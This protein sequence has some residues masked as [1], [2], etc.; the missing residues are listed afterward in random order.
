[1][2]VSQA[3]VGIWLLSFLSLSSSGTSIS[4]FNQRYSRV[5]IL[6]TWLQLCFLKQSERTSDGP[7]GVWV[8]GRQAPNRLQCRRQGFEK[9]M[10]RSEDFELA[11]PQSGCSFSKVVG[12][13]KWGSQP[14]RCAYTSFIWSL[15]NFFLK[16][17][18]EASFG[19]TWKKT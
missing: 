18:P 16:T 4:E 19:A 7:D 11:F 1:M 10:G 15:N 14:F 13:H 12:L 17:H 6:K 3:C 2:Q 5:C 8:T 9:E